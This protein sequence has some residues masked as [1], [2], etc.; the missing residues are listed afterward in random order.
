[1]PWRTGF[2]A[3]ARVRRKEFA[4]RVGFGAFI[5]GA[6]WILTGDARVALWFVA[7]VAVQLLDA[8][9]GDQIMKGRTGRG[10]A[11]LYSATMALSGAVF[12]GLGVL[13]WIG[14]GAAGQIFA[15]LLPAAALLNTALIA[16]RAAAV[17]PPI[18]A[19]HVAYMLGIPLIS[20]IVSPERDLVGLACITVGAAVYVG[21]LRLALQ[22]LLTERSGRERAAAELEETQSALAAFVATVPASVMVTDRHLRILEAS[23]DWLASFGLS[24]EGVRGRSVFEIAPEYFAPFRGAYERC[25]AGERIHGGRVPSP[26]PDGT[27]RYLRAELSPWRDAR[28]EIGGILVAAL[29]ITEMVEALERTERSQQRLKLAVE[30]ADLHVWEADYVR[31]TVETDGAAET[32]FDYE[33]DAET[34]LRDTNS[35]IDPRDRALISEAWSAA[36]L[37]DRPFRPEYRVAR[38]DGR[39]VWATCT[40]KLIRDEAG[41]PLRLIG[42]M[43]NITERKAAE[44]ELRRAKETAEAASLAKSTFLATISHEIRTPLNG[45]L[46]M[47]QAMAGDALSSAQR[48]RLSVIRESGETLLALLNDVLDLSKIEA[49]KLELEVAEFDLSALMRGAH[50]A[51]TAVAERKGLEFNLVVAPEARGRYRSDSTRVRQIVYNLVSNALKFTE[52]G[53]VRVSVD[54]TADGLV[55]EVADTGARHAAGG[56]R[57]SVREVRAG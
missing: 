46:G 51:F 27:L 25:L 40:A 48:E 1:M 38:R 8:A 16:S 26:Q 20:G 37:E 28:G 30:I 21:H 54:R 35:T 41:R 23:P 34:F 52:S 44:A 49:G 24:L 13:T 17:A 6:A 9:V 3:M 19:P 15:I 33:L 5:G 7:T 4:S 43:Q 47:A 36:V 29:D 2:P 18:W 45:V 12:S 10:W 39:E 55:L 42:A 31:R 22:R 53:E 56:P 57:A 14:G 11:S 32:F 50:A